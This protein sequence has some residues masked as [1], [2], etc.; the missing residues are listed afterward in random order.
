MLPSGGIAAA[1]ANGRSER[2]EQDPTSIVL[3]P[4]GEVVL[5]RLGDVGKRPFSGYPL[6]KEPSQLSSLRQPLA[7]VLNDG[8]WWLGFDHQGV[9][10]GIVGGDVVRNG[11]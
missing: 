7:I 5:G 2:A 4:H 8:C 1:A 10:F 3:A 11:R 9:D 6:P